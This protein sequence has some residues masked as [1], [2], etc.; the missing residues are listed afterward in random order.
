MFCAH[1]GAQNA[2]GAKFCAGCGKSVEPVPVTPPPAAIP[3]STA[4]PAAP[5]AGTASPP[6]GFIPPPT[7]SGKAVASLLF[8]FLFF[9]FPFAV[10]AIILGHLALREIRKSAGRITGHGIAIGGLVLGYLGLLLIPIA[11][12]GLAIALPHLLRSRTVSNAQSAASSM[13]TIDEAATTYSATYG[14]GYPRD[15]ET[16]TGLGTE[17]CNH[18]GLIDGTLAGGFRDGYIFLYRPTY[19][20][21]SPDE[22]AKKPAAGCTAAGA[23]G[24]TL[25]ANPMQ[26]ISPDAR[27][28]YMDQTGVIRYETGR[29]ATAQSPPVE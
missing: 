26:R 10:A 8:G 1:C 9:A 15:L 12:I 25:T 29:M 23:D 20:H 28:F 7:T 2:E 4:A 3:A 6:P 5:A 24:F 22:P 11:L 14:N 21:G 17:D 13:R 27:S 18:A 19:H 16:L